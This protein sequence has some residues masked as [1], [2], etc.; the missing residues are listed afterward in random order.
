VRILLVNDYAAPLGGAELQML[1]LREGLRA[2]G[3]DA[4]LFTSRAE[5]G[6]LRGEADY[7]C[8]GTTTRWRTLVQ[9][10]NPSAHRR[11]R[12]VVSEF[13]PDVVHVSLFLTQLSP[14]ILR[15]IADV[16]TIY[17]AVWYR[18]ICPLGTKLLPSGGVCQVR[19]GAVCHRSGCLPLRDWVPLMLQL[20]LLRRWWPSIDVVVADSAYVRQRL[21]ADGLPVDTIVWHSAQASPPTGEADDRPLA[22]FAGRLVREKGAD[23]LVRAF[24]DVV[25]AVP[26]ARLVLAGDG[27]ERSRLER[28]IGRLDLGSHVELLG[29]VTRPE[30][31]RRFETAWVQAVPSRWPEPFGIVAAEAMMRGTAV[32]AADIG[33]LS[34][35]VEHGATGWVVPPNDPDELAAALASLLSDRPRVLTLGAA[36]RAFARQHLTHDVHV[37]RFLELYRSFGSTRGANGR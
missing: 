4:R 21:E 35:L 16:P 20:R 31:E 14:L 27:P 37:E 22:V 8:Y 36:G 33:G 9:T 28:Q 5:P 30:L 26:D 10:A 34:E 13:R 19:A 7:T 29:H 24:A 23:L 32:L 18:A 1:A 3:H 12:S 17:Y 15:A 25:K 6:G 11:L 2:R